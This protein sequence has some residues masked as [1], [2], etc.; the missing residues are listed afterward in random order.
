MDVIRA[1]IYCE[2]MIIAM[3][4]DLTNRVFDH[5]SLSFIK[6]D[7]GVFQFHLLIFNQLLA[8]I[9]GVPY[10]WNL[11]RSTEPCSSP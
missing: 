6:K 10:R 7:G 8:G 11:R 3:L 4:T 9:A 1:S 2:K 5:N